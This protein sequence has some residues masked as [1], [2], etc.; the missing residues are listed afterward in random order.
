MATLLDEIPIQKLK[1]LRIISNE[2]KTD[3]RLFSSI[4]YM[5]CLSVSYMY[6]KKEV[7]LHTSW[8]SKET[9]SKE[10]DTVPMFCA[11]SQ[12]NSFR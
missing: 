2:Q 6:N 9:G 3:L 7:H 5:Y 1:L 12:L 4:T 10:Y 11:A 8:W